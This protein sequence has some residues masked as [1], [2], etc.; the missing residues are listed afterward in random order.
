MKKTMYSL[1]ASLVVLS[2]CG[3][4]A[5]C[6]GSKSIKN[7][8]GTLEGPLAEDS[9]PAQVKQAMDN[10][11][12]IHPHEILSDTANDVSVMSI[13]QADEIST[14]G[15]G[16]MVTKGSQ[17]TTFPQ[18][19]N[20]RQPK[21]RYNKATGDLWLA[22]SAMEGTGV[23]VERLYQIRFKEDGQA[24][25]A[26]TVN[27]YD[28]QQ[29]FCK[30]LGYTTE[31]EKISIYFDEELIDSVK[32][33]VTDMGGF[34]EDALWIGEQIT[35][36][37]TFT[38]HQPCC[39]T[40]ANSHSGDSHSPLNQPRVCVTPGVKFVTGLVLHYDNMPE[41]SA[42]ITVDDKGALTL[43][44]IDVRKKSTCMLAIDKYLVNT[45][46]SQYTQGDICIPVSSYVDIDNT[47]PDEL[48]VLG[49]FW[50]FNF[51]LAGDTLKTVSGGNHPG[52]MHLKEKA[53]SFEVIAFD[54]V[55]DGA[56]NLESAKRIFGDNY[57]A[58]HYVN[59]NDQVKDSIRTKAISDYVKKHGLS[60]TMYQ[61]YGWPAVKLQK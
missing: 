59:G 50:V 60:A 12:K 31:G 2:V 11:K 46:G 5:A 51:N 6:A 3:L 44:D 25:I 24:F 7:V 57:E 17:S 41:I 53:D 48:L 16:I 18:I 36:D 4:F 20:V 1:M 21:A 8:C 15:F 61:D 45:F 32:N 23:Q 47:N 56:G 52:L 22:T 13:D 26:S 34:D 39:D 35:F 29:A 27:P 33:T 37:L 55:E 9:V 30:H 10:A 14:E 38:Y 58:F 19:R 54:Q 43:S 49:D 42:N 40:P 28:V